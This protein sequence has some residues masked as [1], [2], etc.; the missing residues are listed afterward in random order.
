[1]NP[2]TSYSK[3]E[4][5]DGP[6]SPRNVGSD[7]SRLDMQPITIKYSPSTAEE[8]KANSIYYGKFKK[9]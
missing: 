2:D 4:S 9:I 1:V 5:G 3:D 7:L 8:L 6:N